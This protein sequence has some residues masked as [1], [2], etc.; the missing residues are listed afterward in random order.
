MKTFRHTAET[1]YGTFRMDSI[2]RYPFAVVHC[3]WKSLPKTT[4]RRLT[5]KEGVC[6]GWAKSKHDADMLVK[7]AIESEC[8]N[9]IVAETAVRELP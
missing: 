3:G 4:K 6:F 9:V 7:T 5:D 2:I 8:V 1:E